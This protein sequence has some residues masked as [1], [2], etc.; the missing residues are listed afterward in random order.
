MSDF[1]NISLKVKESESIDIFVSE[2]GSSERFPYY[3]GEYEVT[4]SVN[5]KILETSN[6]SMSK[7]VVVLEIPKYQF[8]NLSNGQTVV[9]GGN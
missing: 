9:I 4:P 6:K 2:G 1:I 7:D 8:D 3:K 5:Q